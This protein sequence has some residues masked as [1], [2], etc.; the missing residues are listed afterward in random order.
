MGQT[1]SVQTQTVAIIEPTPNK[2]AE[3]EG[4]S[5][6]VLELYGQGLEECDY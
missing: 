2:E 6:I 5:H 4:D 3:A 1:D